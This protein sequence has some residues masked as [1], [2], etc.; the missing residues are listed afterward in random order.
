MRPLPCLLLLPLLL[1]AAEKERKPAAPPIP[2]DQEIVV[3]HLLN[4]FRG[5]ATSGHLLLSRQVQ[6]KALPSMPNMWSQS[7]GHP[8]PAPPLTINP[9]LMS[10]ARALLASTVTP[11]A[12]EPI[13]FAE[14]LR[15]VAYSPD[16]TGHVLVARDAPSLSAA[17]VRAFTH[18]VGEK[19]ITPTN[20]RPIYAASEAIA[21]TWREVGIAVAPGKN[22]TFSLVVVLGAGSATRYVGGVVYADANRNRRY[23]AGEGKP[24]VQVSVGDVSMTTGAGGAWWLALTNDAAAE[25]TFSGAGHRAVRPLA[26]G[27][28]NQTVDWR[29]PNAADLTLADR[30]IADAEKNPAAEP[31]QR[32]KVLA[33]LLSGTRM[34]ILDDARLTKISS[35]VQPIQNDFDQ[36]LRQAMAALAEEPAEFKKQMTTLKKTW[37]GSLPKLF[38]ELESLYSLRKQVNSVLA[39]PAAQQP[40]LV[41]PVLKQVEKASASS[42]D[43]VCLEM[44]ETWRGSLEAA[45]PVKAK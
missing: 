19:E 21:P 25:V 43:P 9:L 37:E 4:D 35:M 13:T 23:D 20:R 1:G 39:L 38:K 41:P 34:S 16:A 26:K 3:L 11:V 30:L 31:A 5:D 6:M 44:L 14:A 10:A 12:K 18:V 27:N 36:L 29:I 22:G 33:A 32:R 28:T 42:N 15:T 7:L 40:P 17:F 45:V 2:T 24:D 8:K